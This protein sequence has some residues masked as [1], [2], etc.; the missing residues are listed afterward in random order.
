MLTT[1]AT[2]KEEMQITSTSDDNYLTR[3]IRQSTSAIENYCDRAFTRAVATEI[4]SLPLNQWTDSRLLLPRYPVIAVSSVVVEATGA[5]IDS[6]TYEIDSAP[7]GILYRARGWSPWSVD[8]FPNATSALQVP[9][10]EVRYQITYE[11][12]YDAAEGTPGTPASPIP[13]DLER[14]AIELVKS[15]YRARL[16]DPL[17]K[18]DETFG[19]GRL[20]FWVGNTPGSGNL[21]QTV[22]AMIDNYRRL[23]IG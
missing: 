22:V 4:V 16:R 8:Q 13:D 1:L 3:L 14:G 2:V 6:T 12:G 20:E 23:S 17:I 5:V 19:V 15:F 11:A 9:L 10:R 21:P 7:G 18:A